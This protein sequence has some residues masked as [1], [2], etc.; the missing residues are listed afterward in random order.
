MMLA[1]S[2]SGGTNKMLAY[3]LTFF[4][5]IYLGYVSSNLISWIFDVACAEYC[6]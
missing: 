2:K 5:N 6:A 3:F 1:H 4:E